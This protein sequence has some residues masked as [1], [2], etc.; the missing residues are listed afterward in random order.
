MIFSKKSL[1]ATGII[2]GSSLLYYLYRRNIED[3]DEVFVRN[4]RIKLY[5]HIELVFQR[6]KEINLNLIKMFKE[7][8][9]KTSAI[10]GTS[11]LFLLNFFLDSKNEKKSYEEQIDYVDMV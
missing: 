11:S 9:I 5:K 2:F 7:L 1:I 10:I 4:G 8:I 3:S 6:F